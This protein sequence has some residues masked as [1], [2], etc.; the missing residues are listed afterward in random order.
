MSNPKAVLISDIHFSLSTVNIA[1][2]ALNQAMVK[3]KQLNVPLI[4]A[5]D[6][7]DT[8]AL[9][10]GECVNKLLDIFKN[11]ACLPKD[12]IFLMIGNHDLLNEKSKDHSLAFLAPYVTLVDRPRSFESLPNITLIPYFS[13]S[14]ELQQF[15]FN[16]CVPGETL[17][18]HQGLMGAAM[19]EYTVDR[20]S[21]PPE[22]F[23]D[24]RVI[25]GHYHKAQD[26]KCGRPRKGAI[27][28]FSYIGTPYTIT[29]AE[30]NDGPKGFRIL[31]ENGLLESVPTN[32][33]KHVIVE[34]TADT[35]L[36]PIPELAPGDLL[37][38][39]VRGPATELEKL[40]KKAIGLKHLGHQNFKFDKIYDDVKVVEQVKSLTDSEIFDE[41][42]DGSSESK[43]MKK[44]LK[45]MWRGLLSAD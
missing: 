31:L 11:Y 26:I 10:R 34:R 7:H 19:G 8:K 45:E 3:A 5:G 28:L 33:R 9:L 36:D 38:L 37:W 25:S 12:K 35:V 39:K 22:T 30:A 20:T 21:L 40:N 13:S 1:A 24:F 18:M 29:F 44:R 32:L 27:G 2:A 41:L 15:I 6:L 4:I 23:A 16:E 14:D 17:I 43:P 42:I